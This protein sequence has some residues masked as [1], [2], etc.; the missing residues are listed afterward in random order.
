MFR[1]AKV[2]FGIILLTFLGMFGI[3]ANA[4]VYDVDLDNL[5]LTF[6]TVDGQTVSSLASGK[7]K[8]LVFG[9]TTCWNCHNVMDDLCRRTES[10]QSVDLYYI[11]VNDV[12]L[13]EVI[14]YSKD[15]TERTSG[16]TF[17][18]DGNYELWQYLWHVIGND[19]SGVQTPCNVYIDENN[20]IYKLTTG[21]ELIDIQETHFDAPTFSKA[22]VNTVSGVHIYWN[23]VDKANY[24]SI[25]RSVNGSAYYHYKSNVTATNYVDTYVSSG[26]CYSY[27]I[28]AYKDN[29]IYS[30]LSEPCTIDFVSTPD[31]TSRVNSSLGIKLG[32]D[33]SEGATG[34]A[35]YRKTTGAWAR[36]ATVKGNSTFAYTDS[37]VKANNGTVYHYTI[38]ALAGSDLKTLSGCRSTGRTMVRLTSSSVNSLTKVSATSFK[39]TWSRNR[40]ATGYEVRLM[41]GGEVYKTYTFGG[42]ATVAKTLSSLPKGKTYSVQVRSYYKTESA[43][44]Y[45]S[46]WSEKKNI[47]L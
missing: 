34:Y 38:R 44:T 43:G 30:K 35:I 5:N 39:A 22:P 6:S 13:Y 8:I 41:V 10:V 18:Y 26:S 16:I 37:E 20:K 4:E 45:Y 3:K 36:I 9:Q 32:W 11:N 15:Y 40:Q 19:T 29:D 7:G 47:K 24:Y 42:E 17:C 46:G 25:Y 2:L 33:K 28:C 12:S 1:K 23:K 31:I 21:N 14:E 27:K